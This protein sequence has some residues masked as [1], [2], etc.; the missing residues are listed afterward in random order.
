MYIL[1]G[2]RAR[3]AAF[4]FAHLRQSLETATPMSQRPSNKLCRICEN[5]KD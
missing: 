5:Y 2:T 4:I 1:I 3:T